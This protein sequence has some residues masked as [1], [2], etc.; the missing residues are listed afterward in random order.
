MKHFAKNK[1]SF[2]LIFFSVFL[3]VFILL[4]GVSLALFTSHENSDRHA[5]FTFATVSLTDTLSTAEYNLTTGAV[6]QTCSITNLLPTGVIGYRGTATNGDISYAGSVGAFYRIT[7]NV[8]NIVSSVNAQVV[9]TANQ[10]KSVLEFGVGALKTSSEVFGTV[11]AG[12][13]IPRG[14]IQMVESAGNLYADLSF[15]LTITIDVIQTSNIESSGI[16]GIG[17]GNNFMT[18]VANYQALFAAYDA[19]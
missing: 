18:T 10:L 12:G 17:S 19:A 14:Y 6:S 5:S 15:S 8:S 13:V 4:M 9:P 16:S 7:F 11:N 3:A 1:K 2:A